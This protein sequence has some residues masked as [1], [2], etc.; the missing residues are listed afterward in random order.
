MIASD[1]RTHHV[2]Y[3]GAP[4]S[5]DVIKHVRGGFILTTWSSPISFKMNLFGLLYSVVGCI[6]CASIPVYVFRRRESQKKITFLK[7]ERLFRTPFTQN[8]A[9]QLNL[10]NTIPTLSGDLLGGA[11]AYFVFD[12]T[13]C[14]T[15]EEKQVY[16]YALED[17]SIII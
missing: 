7:N 8:F 10:P 14:F 13:H 1:S 11:V 12:Q 3:R 6:R 5:I 2:S 17:A 16:W 15:D 9:G 4:R